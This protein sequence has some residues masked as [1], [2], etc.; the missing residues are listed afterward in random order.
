MTDWTNKASFYHIY[1][2]GA[3]GAPQRNDFSSVPVNR[4]GQIHGWLDHIQP[5]GA[6]ALYL[7]PLFEATAHGYDT[8]N[9]YEVDRRLGT[10][11]DLRSLSQALHQ[12]GMH[13]ILDGVFNHV[14]RDFWAFKDLQEKHEHSAYRDWFVNLRFDRQ[15]QHGDR[16]T[17]E[18]WNGHTSL[19]KL[20]LENSAVREH[21]FNAIRMWVEEFE[22]DGLRLDAA[23]AL[24]FS[25][26]KALRTFCNGLKR[27]FWLMGEVIHGDYRQWVNA[28]TLHSVTNYQLYKGLYSSHNDR[29]YFELAYGLKHQFGSGGALEGLQLYNFVDN[30]DVNRIASQLSNPA[31]LFPLH[32]LLFTIPGI[33]SI[34]YGSEFGMPGR[35]TQWDD[36]PLRPYFD[37][38]GLQAHSP[39]PDLRHT[40]AHLTELRA[41][42]PCLQHGNYAELLV[43]PQQFAFSRTEDSQSMVVVVNS[44]NEARHVEIKLPGMA[45]AEL[46]DQLNP[47]EHFSLQNGS[48]NVSVP[49]CWGRI[50]LVT[51]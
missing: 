45:D 24:S 10:R 42:S 41:A 4:L 30:H 34:Y 25:F 5:L 20:N 14:G 40:I 51:R 16:F 12:R 21:L 17:Y 6:N 8:A 35:R 50:L 7:G 32:L 39:Q 3:L 46:S 9:Y 28:E 23:D 2:L 15:N 43:A 31:H 38:S 47:G 27:D 1:P 48:L 44:D 26:L 22:I 19:V 49:A 13:L 33:P 18:G 37:L 29:N 11:A 36:H